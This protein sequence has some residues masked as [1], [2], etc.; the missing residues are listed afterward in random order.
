MNKHKQ[1]LQKFKKCDNSQD[2]CVLN[3]Y[4]RPTNKIKLKHK[5]CGHTYEVAPYHFLN[6]NR[7]PYCSNTGLTHNLFLKKYGKLF[8]E[9]YEIL[10][11]FKGINSKIKLK[12]KVCDNEIEIN[13]SKFIHRGDRCSFCSRKNSKLSAKIESYLFLNKF[14]YKLEFK[15]DN[16]KYKN[17]LSFDFAIFKQEKLYC[18]IESDG[19]Q[20]F[21]ERSH[22]YNKVNVKR[23]NIKNKYCK[24]NNIQL[25][26]IS[27]KDERDIYNILKKEIGGTI[28]PTIYDYDKF[29]KQKISNLEKILIIK[30]YLSSNTTARK[31]G[32]KYNCSKPTILSILKDKEITDMLGLT[33]DVNDKIKIKRKSPN[34]NDHLCNKF[35][36]LYDKGFSYRA[37]GRKFNC[38]HNQVKAVITKKLGK[39]VIIHKVEPDKK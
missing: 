23:D 27:Y 10:S 18:L 31:L 19:E 30:E 2:Y 14:N 15:F 9:E 8:K 33:N 22:F 11:E 3:K 5:I 29:Y 24:D 35:I 4:V 25:I 32:I 28:T 13:V 36:E 21:Q 12:H 26:R 17:V 16:C 39:T 6:G 7:C 37:I 34:K 1:F 20:H 38:S